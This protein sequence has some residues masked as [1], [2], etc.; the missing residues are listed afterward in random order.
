MDAK[1][2]EP[3]CH[4]TGIGVDGITNQNLI[5]NGQNMRNQRNRTSLCEYK[6][7]EASKILIYYLFSLQLFS[8]S[9]L[10]FLVKNV[11]NILSVSRILLTPVF[12]MMYI[13]EEEFWSALSIAVYA[14]A[15]ITDFFDGYIARN[16]EARSASGD[17]LDPL[18]DKFLTMAGFLCLWYIRP[19]QFPLWMIVIILLRDIGTTVLRMFKS[20]NKT[21][22]IVTSRLAKWKTAMQMIFLYTALIVGAFASSSIDLGNMA[23]IILDSGI[24]YWSLLAVMI[25][26]VWSG[27]DYIKK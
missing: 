23:R 15:A 24:F 5:P 14:I 21:G 16:Y 10:Q 22:A 20:S 1:C 25:L 3:R 12:V 7:V 13:Q 8:S 9:T 18:A 2:C 19:D 26:T 11:P 27:L 6:A 17:F 4:P